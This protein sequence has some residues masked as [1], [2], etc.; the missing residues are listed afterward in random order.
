MGGHAVVSSVKRRTM[1]EAIWGYSEAIWGYSEAIW[2][3]SGAIWAILGV[4]CGHFGAIWA[5]APGSSGQLHLGHS[6]IGDIDFKN[7]RI[8]YWERFDLDGQIFYGSRTIRSSIIKKLR[9]F[10]SFK[11][12][13]I[14]PQDGFGYRG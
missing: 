4:I 5:I 7:E 10:E 3:Y 14:Q 11:N 2:G 9:H 1:S 12:L 8:G 13:P 6:G